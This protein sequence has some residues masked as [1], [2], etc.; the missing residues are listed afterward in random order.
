MPSTGY[1]PDFLGARNEFALPEI[2]AEHVSSIAF[3]R[4]SDEP[5]LHYP[6][7]TVVMNRKTRQAL[8]SAANADFTRNT[9]RGRRFRLDRRIDESLQLDNI[10]YKDLNGIEN[11][12]DRGHLTRRAAIAW[13]D[14]PRQANKASKDSCFFTNVTL[15]HKNVNQDEWHALEKAIENASIDADNRFNIICGP[16]FTGLDRTITP[17]PNLEPGIIPSAFWKIIAY[18]GKDT[19]Q[20]EVNAF[21]VFQDDEPIQR[22]GQVLGNQAIDP[23][24]EYQTS[25]T[26]IEE[27]TGLEFP[28][29]AFDRNPM[30]FFESDETTKKNIT[31]PQLH[32]VA[33]SKGPD[34]GIC[35]KQ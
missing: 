33:T 11:P 28:E 14:S 9:G 7:Y 5:F 35:F 16:I 8:Y 10:Y 31:T 12:Y 19:G 26:L 2:T 15:Q 6:N 1:Q 27:L 21:I 23:F 13:G 32:N 20:L 34:C 22:M 24:K 4:G 17:T 29:E 18:I 25:T 3:P 30:F